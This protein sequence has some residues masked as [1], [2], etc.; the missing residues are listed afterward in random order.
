[1]KRF[2]LFLYL[3]VTGVCFSQEENVLFTIDQ[4][5]YYTDEFVRVYYK[6]IEL[7]KDESQKDLDNYLELF[8]N[9]KLKVEKAKK[10]NLH[11]S[12]KYQSELKSYRDQLAKNYI[13]DPK[14]SDKLLSEA[15]DRIK[16]QVRASH[17]LLK[18]D[19]NADEKELEAI[20]TKLMDIRS[21]VKD[22]ASFEKL[23]VEHSQ[24]PSVKNNKGD[25]GY[26]TAFQMVY[27]FET[28]AYQTKKNQVSMPVKT[29][30]GYHLIF[31]RDVKENQG[32]VTVAHIMVLEQKDDPTKAKTTID[33]VYQ[34]L[35]QG[36]DF[37]ILAKQ[38]SNDKS[39]ASKGGVLQRFGNGQLTSKEFE[40]TA[41]SLKEHNQYSQPFKTKFGWHIVKLLQKHPI[42]TLDDMKYALEEKIRK[43]D[44][45]N[46]IRSALVERLRKKY[47]FEIDQRI[48]SHI[49]QE[50]TDLFYKRKWVFPNE[51]YSIA[52]GKLVIIENDFSVIASDFIDYLTQKQREGLQ[53]KPIQKLVAYHFKDWVNDQLIVYFNKNL[54]NEYPEF[55][56]VVQ[57]YRDGLLLFDVME[58]EIWNK[59]KRDSTGLD[60]Y[61]SSHK[62]DYFWKKSYKMAVYS[63]KE[64][65]T[66]KGIKKRLKKGE[67]IEDI[68]M[69]YNKNQVDVIV[70]SGDFKVD[71]DEVIQFQKK[72]PLNKGLSKMVKSNGYFM[73][74][75]VESITPKKMKNKEDCR[76]KL[77]S[78]YQQHLESSWE[79]SLRNEFDLKIDQAVFENLKKKLDNK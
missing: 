1:M 38:F 10:L 16:K 14:V 53:I 40:R 75:N 3:L 7:V 30:F 60:A 48:Y 47:N 5:P 62:E 31:V 22:L 8:I 73:L 20:R 52:K 45:S 36:E 46:L 49:E 23:A 79:K 55:R 26:F 37:S 18:V 64:K 69:F 43:D 58:K 68:K 51:H 56:H 70:K 78:D 72:K 66:I 63:S 12:R 71:S 13:K 74:A 29:Q 44:R 25:L 34:K 28:T 32:E 15:Y 59:A 35:E 2:I 4:T 54:E 9:F 77:V 57:E 6:N 17:I 11:Q 41:F 50:V 76:G 33:E 61:Y 67:S 21:Q 24:D 27:P 39:S 19:P 65:R 42:G